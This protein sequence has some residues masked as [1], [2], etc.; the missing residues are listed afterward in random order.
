MN[1]SALKKYAPQARLDFI[2]AVTRRAETLGLNPSNPGTVEHNGDAM[3]INGQPF[4]AALKRQ[5]ETLQKRIAEQGFD[6]VMDAIAYTWFNRLVA[7]RYMELHDFLGHGY[8]VL[9]H[10][11]GHAQPEILDHVG[12]LDLDGLDRQRA[13]DLKL[14]DRKSVV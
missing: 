2:D 11:Q 7:I 6:A 12:D 3:L 10:P 14:A 4:A 9:S 8:R 1:K 13:L 5:R